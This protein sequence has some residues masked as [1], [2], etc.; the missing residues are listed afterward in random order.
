MMINRIIVIFFLILVLLWTCS[1]HASDDYEEK[2]LT[3]KKT[4][5]GM[6]SGRNAAVPSGILVTGTMSLYD[7]EEITGIPARDIADELGLPSNAPLNEHLGR[8]RK[9]YRFSMHEIRTVV[10]SLRNKKF[11]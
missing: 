10:I 7:L 11:K 6:V 8:L 2:E 1:P 3:R 4:D 9:K 5:Q